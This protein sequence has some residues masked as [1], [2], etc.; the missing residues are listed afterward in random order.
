M[1]AIVAVVTVLL[2]GVTWLLFKLAASLG[3]CK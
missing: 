2:V 3:S 1:E